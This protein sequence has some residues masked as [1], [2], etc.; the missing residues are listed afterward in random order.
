MNR[1]FLA[2]TALATTLGLLGGPARAQQSPRWQQETGEAFDGPHKG[3]RLDIYPFL[4]T[5]W[6]EWRERHP[7]AVVMTPVPGLVEMYDLMW[8]A[9]GHVHRDERELLGHFR[10]GLELTASL[11]AALRVGRH[12]LNHEGDDGN[13]GGQE[14]RQD[15]GHWWRRV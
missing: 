2:A 4:I 8:H 11:S 12:V 13:D 9:I 6:K 1:A 10:K 14:K 5:T 7:K 3:K 15:P